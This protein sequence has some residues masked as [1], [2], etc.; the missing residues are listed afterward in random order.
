ML[1][2]LEDTKRFL[3][4]RRTTDT[5]DLF[6]ELPRELTETISE[7]HF[8]DGSNPDLVGQQ[9]TFG[10][11]LDEE[12]IERIQGASNLVDLVHVDPDRLGEWIEHSTS[13]EIEPFSGHI[14][15]DAVIPEEAHGS[16]ASA[17]DEAP[18]NERYYKS[19]KVLDQGSEGACVGF[20]GTNFLTA[21]PIGSFPRANIQ[22]LNN[23]AISFYKTCQKIDE[24]PGENY[25]GTSVSALCKLLKDRGFIE[26]AVM[27]TSFEEMVRW[28]LYRGP[29]MISTP[30]HEGC[31]RPNA[32][33]FIR[34]TG[35]KVGGHAILDRAITRWR[36]AVWFNSWGASFG[37]GG[38]GY[39][40]ESDMRWLIS[41]GLRAYAAIQVK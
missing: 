38:N 20:C 23:H 41:Q 28:K 31:Y 14:P 5:P 18:R 1:Q 9:G 25:S 4:T 10:I 36:T 6:E 29:L 7:V 11:D 40:S 35:K 33:G 24:W 17:P 12:W 26:T 30:W 19:G 27:T 8:A 22:T 39:V 15:G 21:T 3:V 34:P 16:L 2:T 13:E 37:F 32:Q